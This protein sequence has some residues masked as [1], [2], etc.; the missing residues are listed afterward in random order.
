MNAIS[1]AS[2]RALVEWLVGS[3]RHAFV[4]NLGPGRRSVLAAC[5]LLTA[6]CHAQANITDCIGSNIDGGVPGQAICTSPVTAPAQGTLP[7]WSDSLGWSYGLC[8]EAGAHILRERAWCESAG[9]TYAGPG[10]VGASMP[11]VFEGGLASWATEFERI[12]HGACDLGM[13]DSGWGQTVSSYNCWTGGPKILNNITVTD[14]RTFSYSGKSR[15]AQGNC[16]QPWTELVRAGR[17]RSIKCPADHERRN[18]PSG[19]AGEIECWKMPTSCDD[20][21]SSSRNGT[22]SGGDS[23]GNPIRLA[24]CSKIQREVDIAPVGSGGLQF[25]RTFASGSYF[26]PVAGLFEGTW[27]YWRH[28][29]SRRIVALAGNSAAIAVAQREGGDLRYFSAAGTELF[30]ADGAAAQLQRLVD[31]GGALTGWRYTTPGLDVELYNAT[32]QLLSIT[33]PGGSVQSLSYSDATTPAGVAPQPGLLI[34]VTDTFGRMLRLTHDS[35]AR[36]NT[37]TDP[38]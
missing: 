10:C 5:V 2:V 9:G 32:G 36:L 24:D 3:L 28:T 21:V 7:G 4:S 12:L 19:A 16:N 13:S 26:E 18:K 35:A 38:A 23:V 33:T 15:D 6:A 20:S 22:S 37:I 1:R 29:Y 17:W 14:F 30:N 34:A 8:D 31:G 11:P 25:V 27:S